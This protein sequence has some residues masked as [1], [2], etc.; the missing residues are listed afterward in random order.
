MEASTDAI[1]PNVKVSTQSSTSCVVAVSV[2]ELEHVNEVFTSEEKDWLTTISINR[3]GRREHMLGG[4]YFCMMHQ[5]ALW[6]HWLDMLSSMMLLL[7][8]PH[9]WFL[10]AHDLHY[11]QGPLLIKLP[12]YAMRNEISAKS[13]VNVLCSSQTQKSNHTELFEERHWSSSKDAST[14]PRKTCK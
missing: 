2:L 13:A 8:H 4:R 12:S 7:L 14:E 3:L 9:F 10:Y 5:L 1:Y 11:F 6:C